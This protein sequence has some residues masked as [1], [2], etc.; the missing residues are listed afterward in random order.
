MATDLKAVWAESIA[1]TALSTEPMARPLPRENTAA[2]TAWCLRHIT[3]AEFT[4]PR[5]THLSQNLEL[6]GMRQH[7]RI[8]YRPCQLTSYFAGLGGLPSGQA[9]M[10]SGARRSVTVT[11]TRATACCP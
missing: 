8:A 6:T 3:A 7:A 9:K 1:A 11:T 2:C 10:A 5:M 4:G